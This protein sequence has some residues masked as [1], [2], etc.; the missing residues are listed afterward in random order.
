MMIQ[1]K[2]TMKMKLMI[3]MKLIMKIKL[4]MK[5][6]LMMKIKLKMNVKMK[7]KLMLK[8]ETNLSTTLYCD[9]YIKLNIVDS[10]TVY[11]SDQI[12]PLTNQLY[13]ITTICPK[14]FK[15]LL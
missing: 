3:K 4:M 7:L 6:K 12:T 14:K 9:I 1:M 15:K 5:M 11:M 10:H 2:L 13:F 8:T